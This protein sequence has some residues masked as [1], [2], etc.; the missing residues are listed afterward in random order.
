MQ[1]TKVV[2]S[3]RCKLTEQDRLRIGA[4]AADFAKEAFD[5]AENLESTRK[6]IKASIDA[7]DGQRDFRLGLLRTGYKVR[8][9]ECVVTYNSPVDGKKMIVRTDTGEDIGLEVMSDHERQE[10]LQFEGDDAA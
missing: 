4:E 2:R 6:A 7:T 9:V 3:L 5:L 10:V 1:N 8:E